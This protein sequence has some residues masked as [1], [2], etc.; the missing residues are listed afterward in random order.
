MARTPGWP[1]HPCAGPVELRAPRL[2]DARGW[3]EVRLRNEAWLTPWEPTSSH[4]WDERNAVSAWPTLHSSLKAAARRGIMLPFMVD[5]GGRLV[6]QVNVSNVVHG[7]LRS[8]T[9]GYWVDSAVAGRNITPTAVALVMDHCFQHVGMHRIEIDI[10]PE[11]KASLRVVEKL[12]L[13]REGY[14]ERFLD[15]DGAWRDHAAFALTVEE[16]RGAT[17]LSRLDRLPPV[18]TWRA[19][20]GGG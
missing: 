7:A 4:A 20:R 12:G 9:I 3:S 16:L 17:M 11:N 14:Y 6:G 18:P 13:R 10:R 8:C 15:I 19:V 1:A 5:Y 2:R